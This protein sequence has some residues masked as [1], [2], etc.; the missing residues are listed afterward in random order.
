MIKPFFF[1]FLAFT[2]WLVILF[3]LPLVLSGC[4]KPASGYLVEGP[5]MEFALGTV[6]SVNLYE[7][8][9]D[10]LLYNKIFTR[11]RE[12][13]NTMSANMADTFLD[14]ISQNAGRS[15]VKVPDSLLDVL[16]K[17]VL[18]AG[19]SG[20]AFDPAI[21]PLVKLWGIGTEAER[22]P[23]QDEI[24]AA[25]LLSDY[26]D[27]VVDREAGT[28]FLKKEGMALDLGA[29]AKGYAA[30]QAV[31]IL[32]KERLE[33]AVIDLGGNIFVWGN[34]PEKKAWFKFF[35]TGKPSPWR[36]GIQDPLDSRG[37]YT[38]ILEVNNKSIVT[39]GVYERFM[40]IDGKRYHHILSA[41]DGYPVDNGL[42]S[43]TIIADRSIDAD[44]LSTTV[45]ALGYERGAALLESP[46]L[47]KIAGK[48]EAIFVFDDLSISL[49]PG[50][51]ETFALT[52]ENYT[53]R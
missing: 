2:L 40:E 6:C 15:P 45:F 22:L 32:K 51:R 7:Q 35:N 23:L 53:L 38:G 30:D 1:R 47:Q 14:R 44:A 46:G 4:S 27:I 50:V 21:G 18:Y 42:L 19:L 20:G 9:A 5:V 31:E 12:I 52:N 34:K 39:S 37:S 16:E 17:A 8:G 28:V 26:R 49:T 24:N 25:L 11:L 10:I 13:E 29:I 33:G 3:P 41:A 48:V 43:V 36:I